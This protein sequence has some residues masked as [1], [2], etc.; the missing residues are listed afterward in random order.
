VIEAKRQLN[1]FLYIGIPFVSVFIVTGFGSDPVNVTKF[2]VLGPIS[3]VAFLLAIVWQR[4]WLVTNHKTILILFAIFIISMINAVVQ[5]DSPLVQNIYGE[6][7][8]NT[9]FLTYV[10]LVMIS[11]GVLTLNEKSEFNKIINGLLAAGQINLVY[12]YWV[13]LFGDPINWNNQYGS[14]LGLFGNP[15]F[16][17][18]FLGMYITV[19]LSVLVGKPQRNGN[20]WYLLLSLPLAF[21]AVLETN[22]VQGL[23]VTAGGIAL[24]TFFWIRSKFGLLIQSTFV[25][26]V[27]ILGFIAIMGTLQKGPLSFVYK[28][29]VSLRGTYWQTGIS[30]GLDHPGSGV[31]MD[32]YGD[33]YRK[34]RPPVALID[35]PGP[36][37][38]S[39]AAHN[40]ILDFFS[41]GGFPLLI[42]YLLILAITLFSGSR[43]MVRTKHYDVPFV[44][45]FSVWLCYQVQSII[46]INQIG[47]AVWGW[48]LTAAVLAYVR[49]TDIPGQIQ[50]QK[51]KGKIVNIVFTPS[52]L[53]ILGIVSGLFLSAPPISSD[54]SWFNARNSNRLESIQGSLKPSY[55]NPES[56][57]KY[58]QAVEIFAKSNLPAEAIKYARVA[59]QFHPNYFYAWRDIYFLPESTPEERKLAK[60]NMKRLDPLNPEIDRLH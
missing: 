27:S 33:W 10:F 50:M 7:G 8:R 5:S 43:Y 40:I 46:S 53:T 3:V 19:A 56:S 60:Y 38:S 48:A 12:C 18:A 32:G 22:A 55:F 29:S 35:T 45:L 1:R 41:F 37:V 17:G 57:F 21:Y 20:F 39:N 24:V 16:I 14:L 6:Y 28:R 42:S 31:G 11:I 58:S 9:G 25:V 36:T 13:I 26:F 59:V 4:D 49:L 2:L 52:L 23:V 30:M 15:N 44:A 34:Y 51:K 54:T 47:L